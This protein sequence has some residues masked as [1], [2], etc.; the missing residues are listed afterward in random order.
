LVKLNYLSARSRESG[1]PAF[2]P[3][4]PLARE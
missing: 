1:D 4:F 3:G 2:G